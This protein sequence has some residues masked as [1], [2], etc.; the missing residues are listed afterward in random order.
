[1]RRILFALVLLM[2]AGALH[3]Q[4]WVVIDGKPANPVVL[5]GNINVTVQRIG[6]NA[7][8]YRVTLPQQSRW[9]L[10]TPA[11]GGPGGD[12]PQT[13][14]SVRFDTANPRIIYVTIYVIGKLSTGAAV[15][16]PGD[17]RFSLEVRPGS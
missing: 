17:A 12:A 15:L 8:F 6:T 14:A 9:I 7:G 2:L 13:V 16:T 3:A 11:A 4:S 10:A 5:N 1:M